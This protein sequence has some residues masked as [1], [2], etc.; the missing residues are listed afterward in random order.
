VAYPVYVDFAKPWYKVRIGDFPTARGTSE[1]VE[2][3][4]ELGYEDAWIVRSPIRSGG[5]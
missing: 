1:L 4:R 5:P 2:R 3:V